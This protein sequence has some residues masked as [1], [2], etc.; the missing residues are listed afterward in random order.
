MRAPVDLVQGCDS[1][2]FA[3]CFARCLGV[4]Y[5]VTVSH[6]KSSFCR[7][8]FFRVRGSRCVV[9]HL[10]VAVALVDIGFDKNSRVNHGK[11]NLLM[12]KDTSTVLSHSDTMT[13]QAGKI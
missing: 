11:M 6:L 12:L 1:L 10:L 13:T 9:V 2:I 7:L 8:L 5:L 4:L 3:D